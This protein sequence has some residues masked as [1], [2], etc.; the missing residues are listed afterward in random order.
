[1]CKHLFNY[2]VFRQRRCGTEKAVNRLRSDLFSYAVK[3]I[4]AVVML[5]ALSLICWQVAIV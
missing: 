4:I 2:R 1:M 3:M 5:T